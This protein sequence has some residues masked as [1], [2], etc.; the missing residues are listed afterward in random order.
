MNLAEAAFDTSQLDHREGH[1]DRARERFLSVGADALADYEVLELVL[2]I[3]LPR[4]DTKLLAKELLVRFGSFSAV[5]A[6][7]PER[8]AEVKGLGTVSI[9]NLKILQAAA[10]RYA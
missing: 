7:A 6:A 9:A 10:Q 4:R 3:L 5:L 2:H 8:L 1:R